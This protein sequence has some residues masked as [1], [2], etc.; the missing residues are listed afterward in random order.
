MLQKTLNIP[1][2]LD[3]FIGV[4]NAILFKLMNNLWIYFATHSD[5]VTSLCVKR[6][7]IILNCK[8]LANCEITEN[9]K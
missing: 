5:I 9:V 7:L 6:N 4:K 8:Q 2:F 1:K 3:Y